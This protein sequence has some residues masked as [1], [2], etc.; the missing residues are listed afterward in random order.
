MLDLI[1]LIS[2]CRASC[3]VWD[4]AGRRGVHFTS[5]H[6]FSFSPSLTVFPYGYSFAIL[7]DPGIR[8]YSTP[9]ILVE[10][11]FSFSIGIF[12]SNHDQRDRCSCSPSIGRVRE[13]GLL[14]VLES[15]FFD[16]KSSFFPFVSFADDP[17]AFFTHSMSTSVAQYPSI[18][19]TAGLQTIVPTPAPIPVPATRATFSSH[20]LMNPP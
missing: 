13:L 9:S 6:F 11:G 10:N 19:H 18:A 16:F 20:C 1:D 12:L 14:P 2:F 5:T 15:F 17:V 7:L 4:C 8:S 3:D